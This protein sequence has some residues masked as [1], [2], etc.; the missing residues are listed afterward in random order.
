VLLSSGD[1]FPHLIQKPRSQLGF[2]TY[3][4]N[5]LRNYFNVSNLLTCTA[6]GRFYLQF[7]SSCLKGKNFIP[8][9]H[10]PPILVELAWY[11]R[12]DLFLNMTQKETC[13]ARGLEA[14]SIQT[15]HMCCTVWLNSIGKFSMYCWSLLHRRVSKLS[16]WKGLNLLW[17]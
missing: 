6:H 11:A 17:M 4:L 12:F 10:C 7:S 14:V 15:F 2:E 13:S 5:Y 1:S 16:A 8:Q 3:L 9:I